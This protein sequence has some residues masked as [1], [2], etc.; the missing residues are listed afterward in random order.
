VRIHERIWRRGLTAICASGVLAVMALAS[1]PA[2][3][4]ATVSCSNMTGSGSTL[5]TGFQATLIA[6]ARAHGM[7]GCT[8]V[9]TI[10]YNLPSG[11][12]SGQALEE[13]GLQ[14]TG[15]G[16]L[17]PEKAA[18]TAHTLDE[19]I[20]SDD[21]PTETEIQEGKAAGGSNPVTVPIVAAPIAIILHRPAGCSIAGVTTFKILNQELDLVFRHQQTW[22][23]LVEQIGGTATGTSCADKPIVEVRSD[24]SGTSF[25]TKQY[26][27]QIKSKVWQE[28]VKDD[29]KW[30]SETEAKTKHI[31]LQTMGEVENKGSGGEAAAVAETEN[32]I[33]YVNT[34]NAHNAGF[35]PWK[36]ASNQI[37]FWGQ[38]QN[39]GLSTQ[40]TITS[41]EPIKT[42]ESGKVVG[43]CPK[44]YKFSQ[45]KFETRVKEQPP[46]WSGVELANPTTS[47][48]YPLCTFTYD[49]A[50][51]K[52][53]TNPAKEH[54]EKG[55]TPEGAKNSVKEYF[56]YL[57][58]KA[59]GQKKIGEGIPEY[60]APL[61]ENIDKIAEETVEKE[62]A[63][64]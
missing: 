55:Q 14:G 59:L 48:A 35:A 11:T 8:V 49:L 2:T 32:S 30:P 52:Y 37:K 9:P 39:N 24:G 3:S 36:E 58:G 27:S 45:V 7:T 17:H 43:N 10:E 18:N 1:M 25:A 61:P 34:E 50:W 31:N 40:G 15:A 26:L 21:P 28:F 60:F 46:Q 19:Y 42:L 33:G 54:Y 4:L 57:V 12:G 56:R 44:E 29:T 63:I 62:V 16:T 13:W 64:E 20:D 38:V 47:G 22:R 51:E 53:S 5:Q 23:Q 41:A 6:E